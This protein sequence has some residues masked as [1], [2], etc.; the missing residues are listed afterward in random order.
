V[1][2]PTYIRGF[3]RLV[4]NATVH[5]D[6]PNAG[7]APLALVR[8]AVRLKEEAE[9]E[10]A[11]ADDPFAAYD[12]V[13]CVFDIDDHP[14]IPEA[15]Q[16]AASHGVELAISNP[17]F[18]LWLVLHFRDSPGAQHRD[19]VHTILR[20]FIPGYDKRFRF[21]VV[22]SGVN[23]A[24]TRARRMDRDAQEMGELGRNPSTSVYRLTESIARR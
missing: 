3:E 23:D 11:R 4:R 20:G 16:L 14:A 7:G 17:C 6:I 1:T 12:E 21:E 18:E 10:A 13:W 15:R 19:Q 9:Q 22:V 24:A 2:E 8:A 5:I